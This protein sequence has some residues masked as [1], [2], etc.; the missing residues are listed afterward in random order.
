[1]C[2]FFL[3]FSTPMRVSGLTE[4]CLNKTSCT[5]LMCKQL[6]DAFPFQ[7]YLKYGDA[8]A[9]LFHVRSTV[10]AVKERLEA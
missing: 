5:I 2:V 8:T 9:L 3:S 10:I 6:S 4:L 1:M 7:N